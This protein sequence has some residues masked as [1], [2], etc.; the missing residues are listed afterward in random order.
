[1]ELNV[2]TSQR[3]YPILI[4]HGLLARA[5][6]HVPAGHACLIV[7]DSG[8]PEAYI[9]QLQAQIP[10]SAVHVVP[11][12]EASKCFPQLEEILRDLSGRRFSRSDTIVALGGGVVGD[13]AGFAAAT[14]QRGIRFLNIPTTSLAQIDSSIG[15]KTAID[16]AGLKNNVGAFW[17]PWAVLVDPDTLKSLPDRQMHNGLAEAVK[18]GLI[19]DPALFALFEQEDYPAHL[20]E[21]IRRSLEVKKRIVEADEREGGQR[22]LLNFGHTFGHAYESYYDMS[23]YLHGECV[24]MGMAAILENAD[25]RQRL[26]Q[27]L[28]RLQLPVRCDADPA[29]ILELVQSDKKADHGRIT[30]VEV[31][32]IGR[33]QL[34]DVSIAQLGRRI[35]A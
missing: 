18:T 25:I 2:H 4:E 23:R 35:G 3:D 28:N 20:D 30:I 24:A 27:V 11:Q 33:A 26:I 9:R 13:L 21:I 10:G 15:G 8:V 14:Y 17:Q 12:G 7:S 32:E 31:N 1:M 6:T 22:K 16:F 34:K 19:A 29:R 5:G